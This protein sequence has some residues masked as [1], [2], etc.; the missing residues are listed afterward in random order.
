MTTKLERITPMLDAIEKAGGLNMDQ[1]L[2][3]ELSNSERNKVA[4]SV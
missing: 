3:K 1:G 4:F 2:L